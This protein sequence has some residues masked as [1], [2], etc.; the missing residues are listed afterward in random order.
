MGQ[1][2]PGFAQRGRNE[3]DQERRR[4]Y[5]LA[6][7]RWPIGD[8]RAVYEVLLESKVIE[9]ARVRQRKDVYG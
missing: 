3:S 8:Y 9:I 5:A 6:R 2:R 1:R 4:E 7:R